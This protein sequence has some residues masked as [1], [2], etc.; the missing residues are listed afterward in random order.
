MC[1][2]D[3]GL[4]EIKEK[5]STPHVQFAPPQV[6][7]AVALAA[8]PAALPAA[9]IPLIAGSVG[10]RDASGA[11]VRS[12]ARIALGV[13]ILP[14]ACSYCRRHSII[15]LKGWLCA[16]MHTWKRERLCRV[17][18]L[19]EAIWAIRQMLQLEQDLKM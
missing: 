4:K 18:Q 1:G 8:L 2:P 3:V 5:S 7:G 9:A 15:V 11:L 13:I 6:A 16:L 12:L 19:R 14:T 10:P 17:D